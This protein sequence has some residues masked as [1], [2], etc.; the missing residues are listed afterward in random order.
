[1]LRWLR[2]LEQLA[3]GGR[4]QQVIEHIQRM[5]PEYRPGARWQVQELPVTHVALGSAVS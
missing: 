4:E 1:M 2:R 5:V 3:A